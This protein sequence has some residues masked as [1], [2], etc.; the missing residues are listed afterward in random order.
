VE[1]ANAVGAARLGLSVRP[2]TGDGLYVVASD[3]RDDNG[4]QLPSSRFSVVQASYRSTWTDQADVALPSKAWFEKT[5]HTTNLAGRCLP[6][7]RSVDAPGGLLNDWQ[8]LF[9]LSVK[10]GQP[11]NCITVNEGA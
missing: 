11:L 7:T 5:G 3:E 2:V 8:T 4:V 6:L 1:G 10:M 9:M